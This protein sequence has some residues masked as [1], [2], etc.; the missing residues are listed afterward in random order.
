MG[1][2]ETKPNGQTE[3]TGCFGEIWHNIASTLGLNYTV[4]KAYQF[5]VNAKSRAQV[6]DFTTALIENK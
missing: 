3:L 4:I 1:G 2:I 6:V 5:G